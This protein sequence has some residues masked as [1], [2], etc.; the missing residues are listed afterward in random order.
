M[1]LLAAAV[2]ATL[3]LAGPARAEGEDDG[4]CRNGLFAEQNS[5]FGLARVTG[6][7]RAHFLQDMDS[8]PND[9]AAC[10][11]KAY[12]VTGDRVVTGRSKGAY[13]CAFF[14]NA[15]GGSAGWMAKSRLAALPVNPRPAPAAWLGRWADGDN[16]VRFGRLGTKGLRVDG[17]AWWPSANPSPEQRPGGPNM[18][19]VSGPLRLMSNRAFEPGCAITFHLLGDVL[20]VS[21]PE[22]RCD[23]MNVTFS[24]VY[25]RKRG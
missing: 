8:C 14:T 17:M 11:Q 1:R 18:G 23:G 7:G 9:S 12:L 2:F 5:S 19:E 15:G 21:D 20:V 6:A 22:R 25:L 10:R 13:V 4:M 3:V 24:G 16:W